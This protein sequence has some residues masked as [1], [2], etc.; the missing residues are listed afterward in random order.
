LNSFLS[1]I[2]YF[3]FFDSVTAGLHRG[4]TEKKAQQVTPTKKHT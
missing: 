1:T 3:S 4:H 2:I